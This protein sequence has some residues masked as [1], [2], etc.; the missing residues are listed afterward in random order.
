MK[1]RLGIAVA[2]M[3]LFALVLAACGPAA[4]GGTETETAEGT[5]WKLVS[6]LTTENETVD[7]LPGTEITTMFN[8]GEISGSGSCNRYLGN[9]TV[10]GD[11]VTVKAVGTTQ[12]WCDPEELMAQE[13][14]FL[15]NLNRAASYK[16][17]GN[18][19][20]VIDSDG[21]VLLTYTAL[22][23]KP[24][25]GTTWGLTSYNNGKGGMTSPLAGSD[26]TAVFG[27]EANVGGSAGCNTYD[28][29]YEVDGLQ[30]SI[31]MATTTR[32]ACAEPEGVMEQE[33]AYLAALQ[34]AAQFEIV[35]DEL[36]LLNGE[37]LKAAVFAARSAPSALALELLANAEYKTEWT[38]SGVVR[39]QNGEYRAPAAPGSESEIVIEI[40]E[41]VATGEL[42][43]LSTGNTQPGAA[44]IL[45]SSGGGSGTFY[46]L[47]AMVVRNGQPYDAAWTQLGDRVQ[48]NS[49]SIE[50]GEI[51]V[52]MVT[53]GPED[54]L[55]CPT[56][57]VVQTYALQ[58]DE[59]LQTSP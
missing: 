30:I 5:P 27:T 20:Q 18:Q 22:E 37:G 41:Y 12:M 23:P 49:L 50:N 45:T 38:T 47:H 42:K 10:S 16:I 2:L 26:I 14:I 17:L 39:L 24:L 43:D 13:K 54:P 57:Q 25:V 8:Q 58:G 35:G 46:E 11:Q 33:T 55:C 36:V 28:A 34:T 56:Q 21:Y 32:M 59:L 1:A 29:A 6:Y 48:I 4:T 15:G 3:T 7:L 19:L 44:V 51:V 53:H 40:T 9:Y 31:G 52:D